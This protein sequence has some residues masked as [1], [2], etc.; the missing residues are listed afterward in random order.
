M[1]PSKDTGRGT[2]R[3]KVASREGLLK[4]VASYWPLK[5]KQAQRALGLEWLSE[6]RKVRMSQSPS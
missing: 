2:Q 3:T 4:E 6:G 5:D 1:T